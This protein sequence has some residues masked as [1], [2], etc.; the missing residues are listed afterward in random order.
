MP[1]PEF[2]AFDFQKCLVDV[3]AILADPQVQVDVC[4]VELLEGDFANKMYTIDMYGKLELT[5]LMV[6]RLGAPP[7]CSW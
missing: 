5:A 3:K 2:P 6:P 1:D 7:E 4:K